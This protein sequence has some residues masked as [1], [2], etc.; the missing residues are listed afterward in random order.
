MA[1]SDEENDIDEQIVFEY[2]TEETQNEAALEEPAQI[3]EQQESD[4]SSRAN[5][6]ETEDEQAQASAQIAQKKQDSNSP[7]KPGK[8]VEYELNGIKITVNKT[9]TAPT[10]ERAYHSKAKRATLDETHRMKLLEHVQSKQQV[11]FHSINVSINDPEK[12]TNTY[13]LTTLLAE[14]RRHLGKY[15]L[16]DVY[17]IVKPKPG[18]FDSSHNDF[19]SLEL[20]SSTKPVSQDLFVDYLKLTPER[21]AAS[22]RWYALFVPEANLMQEDLSWSLSYYEK[23]VEPELYLKVYNKLMRHTTAA[24]GGPLFLKILLDCVTTTGEQN[25]KSLIQIVETYRIKT[26]S[27][28][29]DVDRVVNMFD[30]IFDN[31]DTLRNGVLP[32][33]SVENLLIVFQSTSV[34]KFN[35]YFERFQNQLVDAEIQTAIDPTHQFHGQGSIS[36]GNNMK[37]VKHILS[38]AETHYRNLLRKGEWDECLQKKPGKS[39]F[40][41][42]GSNSQHGGSQQPLDFRTPSTGDKSKESNFSN[43]CFNCGSTA[44]RLSDCPH[45]RDNE[46]IE[47]NRAKHPAYIKMKERNH[48]WRPPVQGENNKRVING[49]PHTFNPNLGRRGRWVEDSTPHDG[50]PNDGKPP[51]TAPTGSS[52]QQAPPQVFYSDVHSLLSGLTLNKSKG[53]PSVSDQTD[54]SSE[55]KLAL[56]IKISNLQREFDA[57]E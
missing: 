4:D 14:N 21:V 52:S 55:T 17:N 25:L 1:L 57:L 35:S 36:L 8:M 33:N 48:R 2:E 29:E 18:T 39:A 30:A 42:D 15:D 16:L 22:S 31:I 38:Y 26:S 51:D 50:Q 34:P 41:A 19:G 9:A 6:E 12:M 5:T 3:A 32:P 23:N 43:G 13:T 54:S 44:H 10:K 56:A 37:S 24:R 47:R 53:T 46:L 40:L 7:A 49:K 45:P 20:D 28:G 11:K 27:P